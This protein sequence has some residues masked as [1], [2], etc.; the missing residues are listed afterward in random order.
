MQSVTS[1]AVYNA[2]GQWETVAVLGN[3][4]TSFIK[5]LST[6]NGKYLYIRLNG[7]SG[8]TYNNGDVLFTIPD[9]WRPVNDPTRCIVLVDTVTDRI[10]AGLDIH[11]NGNV[12]VY[13]HGHTPFYGQSVTVSGFYGDIF[14]FIG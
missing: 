5:G 8:G 13:F 9:G 6:P 12:N 14:L 7:L 1:N 11:T 4:G 3:N 2:I 10:T